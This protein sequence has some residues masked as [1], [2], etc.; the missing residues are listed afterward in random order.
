MPQPLFSLWKR[1][2]LLGRG[3][4]REER[5]DSPRGRASCR[6]PSRAQT[7]LPRLRFPFDMSDEAQRPDNREQSG[8][9]CGRGPCRCLSQVAGA[10]EC[11]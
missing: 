1:P 10:L 11:G 7:W 2:L 9:F 8:T 3:R 4:G 6:S 5:A